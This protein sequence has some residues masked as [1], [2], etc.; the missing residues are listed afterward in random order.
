[1]REVIEFLDA[2]PVGCLGTIDNGKPRVRP[3][4]SM[5][6]QD[7]KLYFCTA[8]NKEVFK[9][10]QANPFIEFSS[11]SKEFITVRLRGQ[12][13]LSQDLEIKKRIIAGNELV[14]SIYQT[15]ENPI[16]EIFYLEH[17]SVIMSDFSGQPPK[18]FEF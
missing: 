9:Q 14:R 11:S 13:K 7:D 4:Q 6:E 15:P 8:N 17:G 1:M 18:K 2:N 10:L 16:F 3:F 12:I 5:F